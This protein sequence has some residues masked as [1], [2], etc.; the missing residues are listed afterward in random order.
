MTKNSQITLHFKFF[1]ITNL[2]E[3]LAFFVLFYAER[4]SLRYF[5]RQESGFFELFINGDTNK[6][7]NF[8]NELALLPSSIFLLD[9][10]TEKIEQ[11]PQNTEDS[12]NLIDLQNKLKNKFYTQNITPFALK[13]GENEFGAKQNQNA[14]NNALELLKNNKLAILDELEISCGADFSSDYIIPTKLEFLPKIFIADEKSLISLCAFEKPILRLKTSGIYRNANKNAPLFFSIRAA[15]SLNLFA[16]CQNLSE[17]NINFISIKSL[18]KPKNNLKIE[19]LQKQICI[20]NS[21]EFTPNLNT[22]Q[23][24]KEPSEPLFELI[25]LILEEKFALD[26]IKN[27]NSDSIK[28]KIPQ[29]YALF[30]FSKD[31]E[32]KIIALTKNQKV[33]FLKLNLPNTFEEIY[34]QIAA[35]SPL[36]DN[37]SKKFTLKS[38]AIQKKANNFYSLFEIIAQIL[39]FPQNTQIADLATDFALKKGVRLDF[40]LKENGEFDYISLIS[41]SMSFALAGAEMQN[42]TFGLFE[43]LAYFISSFYDSLKSRLDCECAALLGGFFGEKVLAELALK[44]TNAILS[45]FYP[46]EIPQNTQFSAQTLIQNLE[47]SN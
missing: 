27:I 21:G 24:E 33:E 31:N 40:K 18:Q 42:I 46:L 19:L 1:T 39:H 34:N 32:D 6:L 41:S 44:H 11:M 37:F 3:H 23:S 13:N 9:S 16:L 12:I 7:E 17:Q 45:E 43:S 2:A 36:V 30:Y 38:G 10:S 15:F 26:S 35:K 25:N 14:I 47:N 4:S 29:N 20:K 5:L 22:K 28:N 8:S